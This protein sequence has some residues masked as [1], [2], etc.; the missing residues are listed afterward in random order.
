MAITWY[1]WYGTNKSYILSSTELIDWLIDCLIDSS[2]WLEKGMA[3]GPSHLVCLFVV[4]SGQNGESL[5]CDEEQ[6]VVFT[7]ALLDVANNKVKAI[8]GYALCYFRRA[9]NLGRLARS[10]SAAAQ[11]RSS[12]IGCPAWQPRHSSCTAVVRDRRRLSLCCRALWLD[13]IKTKY[14]YYYYYMV[15]FRCC[16]LGGDSAMPGGLHALQRI[17]SLNVTTCH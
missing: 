4:T 14:Y 10:E 2:S 15:F 16:S 3:S 8:V 17:S 9:Q 6:I 11:R 7:Y 12:T 1:D 5:G 13:R